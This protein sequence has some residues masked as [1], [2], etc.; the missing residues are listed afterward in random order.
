MKITKQQIIIWL[1]FLYLLYNA[2][3]YASIGSLLPITVVGTLIMLFVLGL[4]FKN[5]KL[6]KYGA[7]IWA[8]YMIIWAT[9]RLIMP[10]LLAFSP[11]VTESHIRDQFGIVQIMISIAFFIGGIL[12]FRKAQPA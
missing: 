4:I 10:I 5:K 1:S 8:L 7:R 6:Q 9:V 11:M 2:I 3:V 12:L